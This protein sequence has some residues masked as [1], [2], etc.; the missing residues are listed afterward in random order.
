ME[1][2]GN[3]G[4]LSNPIKHADFYQLFRYYFVFTVSLLNLVV[5]KGQSLM[6]EKLPTH[7][8]SFTS[9]IKLVCLLFIS[10]SG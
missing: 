7:L 4:G 6:S 8:I 2:L 9:K 5:V 10:L 1:P 3:I